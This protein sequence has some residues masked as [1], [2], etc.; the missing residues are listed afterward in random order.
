MNKKR[1]T[2]RYEVA[3]TETEGDKIW[4]GKTGGKG[5]KG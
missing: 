4:K 1:K 2:G 5:E 3:Q